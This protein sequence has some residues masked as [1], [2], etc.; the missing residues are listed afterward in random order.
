[1]D[2]EMRRTLAAAEEQRLRS[3]FVALAE[4]VQAGPEAYVARGMQEFNDK[5]AD[6]ELADN[7]LAD[8]GMDDDDLAQLLDQLEGPL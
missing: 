2:A 7:V 3:C 4:L 5:L 6:Y 1:M 8:A